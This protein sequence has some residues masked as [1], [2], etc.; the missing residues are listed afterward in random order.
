MRVYLTDKQTLAYYEKKASADFWDD[1]WDVG[2][3]RNHILSCTSDGLFIPRVKQYL[4]PG[5]TVLEGGCGRGLLVNALSCQG[6]NAIGV[7]FAK[8][9]VQRI[10]QAVP[11][12]DI[13]LGD[14]K[15]LPI[16]NNAIDGYIS[17]GVIE[18]YWEGYHAILSEM[19]RTLKI[20]GFLFVSFPYMSPLRILK[21]RVG[22]Y[23]GSSVQQLERQQ[24]SFYQFALNWKQVLRDLQAFGFTLKAKLSFDGIKGFKDE[25]TL[26]KPILQPIYDSKKYQRSKKYLDK[27]LK[28]FASHCLLLIMQKTS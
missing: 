3:L 16:D 4:P 21:V 28:N 19:R 2:D 24:D 27:F 6:Y 25:I 14:V 1:H 11:E 18:H 7:D 20:G 9:T 8:Q 26:F 12:L 5:S 10:K 23:S 13:R 17:V 22:A 15:D